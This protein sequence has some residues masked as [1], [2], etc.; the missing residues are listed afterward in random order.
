QDKDFAARFQKPGQA[1]SGG[2]PP[3][4]AG[5]QAPAAGASAPA[6]RPQ[7][8]FQLLEDTLTAPIKLGALFA[9]LAPAPPPGYAVMAVNVLVYW[10]A[11]FAINILHVGITDPAA[12][13]SLGKMSPLAMPLAGGAALT[14]AL[15][16][17]L[18]GAAVLHVLAKAAG[19]KGNFRRSYQ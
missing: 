3:A 6:Q 18:P 4:S 10:G 11:F 2:A 15:A 7:G 13:D 5:A 14:L 8:L 19:G 17:S 1:P 16:G 9:A 12:L